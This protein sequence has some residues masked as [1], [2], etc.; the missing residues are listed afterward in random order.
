MT[1]PGHRASMP[2][3]P[4]PSPPPRGG[5]APRILAGLSVALLAL[6]TVD[7]VHF[8]QHPALR[9]LVLVAGLLAAVPLLASLVPAGR[10]DAGNSRRVVTA[11]FVI[12]AIGTLYAIPARVL[13]DR[14]PILTDDYAVHYIQ[15]ERARTELRHAFRAN[16]YSPWFMAGYPAGTIFDV[17]MKGA[18]LF[19]SVLPMPTA[20]ALKVFVLAAFLALV[21]AVYSGTRQLGFAIEES[22]LGLLLFLVY[23]HWGRPY[24]GDFRYVGMFSFVAACY[25]SLLLAG[26]L[27]S[28]LHGTHRRVF[29]ILGP[30][31]FL[32]H[33]STAVMVVAPFLSILVVHRGRLRRRELELLGIWALVVVF[34]NV[35]WLKPVIEFLPDKTETTAYYQMT[36]MGALARLL[37]RPT[38]APALV[39]LV[40]A[41]LGAWRLRHDH[42]TGDALPC[43]AAVIFLLACA[44]FGTHVPGLRQMEPGRFLL[45]ALVFAVPLAGTGSRWILDRFATAA[46]PAGVGLRR[47]AI[48]CFALLPLPLA[49]L[50]AKAFY[51]HTIG[52]E[53]TPPVERFREAIRAHVRPGARLMIE[54]ANASVYGG[55]YFPAL[56]PLETHVEQIGGPYPHTPLRHARTS[57]TSTRILGAPYDARD[58]STLRAQLDFLRVRW[59]ATATPGAARLAESIPGISVLWREPP[60]ALWELSGG[61]PWEPAVTAE[62]DRIEATFASSAN[63]AFI[64][65][66]WVSGL[67][68]APPA[69]IVP[70]LHDDDPV[71]YIYVRPHGATRVVIRYRG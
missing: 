35:L 70:A 55:T 29:F 62:F 19:C 46:G 9:A 8:A 32:L 13:F 16:C 18:E 59:I 15:C 52:L 48:V 14:R 11:L 10:I 40:A 57:F 6:S 51:H 44:A 2:Q 63:G 53:L 33:A 37:L 25:F 50:E 39:L 49:M 42:R 41:A 28:F 27:R 65:Y 67:E 4:S 7:I 22:V 34:V 43:A 1:A 5:T 38:S 30:L 66:H 20:L 36:G 21:L 68:V 26:I 45:G 3:P 61:A 58:P 60:F 17:D 47:A 24:A 31:V 12:S 23:W 54:D 64:P 71:P 56:L 69:E